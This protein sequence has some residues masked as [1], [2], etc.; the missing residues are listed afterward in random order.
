MLER[1]HVVQ[2][3]GQLDEHDANVVDHGQH[4]LAQVFRLLLFARGEINF[5]DLGDAFDNVRDL[6]AEFFA[7]VDDGDRGIFYRVVQQARGDRDRIHLHFSEN[8]GDFQRMDEVRFAGSAALALHDA[9]GNN[10][11]LS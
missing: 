6:L 7:D 2:A 5:A 8:Q 1:P 4:H 3:V 11:R 10:R 9:S